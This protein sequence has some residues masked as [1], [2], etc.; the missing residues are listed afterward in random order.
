MKPTRGRKTLRE[1][2]LANE[3]AMGF[4]AAMAGKPM[5]ERAIALPKEP[6]KRMPSSVPRADLLEKDIQKQILML[7]RKHPKIHWVARFNSGTFMDGDRYI[8]SNSQ[9]GM[10]DILGML[11]GGRL[12]AIECKSRTGRIDKHQ[13]DF[14]N[15]INEGGGLGFIARSVDDVLAK[16]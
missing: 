8:T 13:Q 4:Y 16:L 2:L 14:L 11:K 12:L 7:L 6:K 15:L 5:P 9:R 1:T 10:S 3:K